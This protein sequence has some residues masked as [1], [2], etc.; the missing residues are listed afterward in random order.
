MNYVLD[1][2]KAHHKYFEELCYIPHPPFQEKALSEYVIA[3]AKERG[4]WYY[5]DSLYNVV[6]KKP[7]TPGYE[8]AAPVMLQAHMDMVCEKTPEKVFHFETDPLQLQV[9]DGWV[10]ATDTTLG[11]DD[12]YGVAYMLAILDADDIPH[13]A[14]ECFFSVQEEVGIGGPRG[15]DYSQLSARRY[16]NLDGVQ[17]G[18]TNVSTANVIGRDFKRPIVMQ[19]NSKPCYTVHICGLSAGHASLNIVKDQANAVKLAARILFAIGKEAKVHLASIQGGTIR[20]GIAEECDATFACEASEEHIRDIVAAVFAAAREE[21]E[22]TDPHMDIRLQPAPTAPLV[23]DDLSSSEAIHLLHVLPSGSHMTNKRAINPTMSLASRN[24]G[25]VSSADGV[26]TVGYMFRCNIK[27]QLWDLFDQTCL[28][29]S[30]FG[31]YYDRE[32]VY[33]GYTADTEHSEMLKLWQKV[34]R[35]FTGKELYLKYTHGG[36]DIGS[37]NDGMGGIDAIVV[38]PDIKFVHRPTEAM[39][40]ASFDRT[41]EY[42]KAI[43]AQLK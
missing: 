1:S 38:S 20:N 13:P 22:L 42:V 33:A 6:V 41:F 5:T 21:H 28:L 16:I 43:L 39:D 40:L 27:S 11:A 24:M 37:I 17:E 25:N 9:R 15:M 18:S 30:R 23:M 14:L 36:S 31:A 29:A 26:L 32:Y 34:Y 10:M 7:A 35:D 3:F 19:E 4:L 8:N 2:S 12:G